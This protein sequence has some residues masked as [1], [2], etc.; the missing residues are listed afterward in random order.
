MY[1]LPADLFAVLVTGIGATALLDLWSLLRRHWLGMPPP[2]Y[3]HVGRW[4]AGFPRGRLMVDSIAT[5][6]PVR[7]E[8]L[9]GWAVHYAIGIVYALLLVLLFGRPWLQQPTPGPA[10]LMGIATVAAPFFLMQPGMGAGIAA[11]RTPNPPLARLHSLLSHAFFG[12]GMYGSAW[13]AQAMASIG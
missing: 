10:L 8:L 2:N 12:L 9:L 3:G 13:F 6:A 1:T 5:A 11:S 4:I 7:G